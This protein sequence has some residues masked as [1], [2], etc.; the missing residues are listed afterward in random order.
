MQSTD[1]QDRV[2]QEL[3]RRD[4][5]SLSQTV[6]RKATLIV[7]GRLSTG[8][9]SRTESRQLLFPDHSSARTRWVDYGCGRLLLLDFSPFSSKIP[10]PHVSGAFRRLLSH[11]AALNGSMG[12]RPSFRIPYTFMC[13]S[14]HEA[15]P[16]P[17][18]V[19]EASTPPTTPVDVA[20][21]ERSHAPI[22]RTGPV[23]LSFSGCGFLGTYH[24]GV[25]ICFQKHAKGLLSRCNKI[26]GASAGSL[27]SSL[28]LLAPDRMEEGLNNLYKLAD[29]LNALRFGALTPRF[30]LNERLTSIV[31]E[32][33]PVNISK[34]QKILHISLTNQSTRENVLMSSFESRECLLNCLMASCFIPMYSSGIR[35]N[36]PEIHG[37]AYID[38]GFS[39][40][41]HVFSDTPTITVSPFSGNARIAPN[42]RS[43]LGKKI[44][45][46][47]KMRLGGQYLN[48]NMQNIVRGAQALFPPTREVLTS[49]YDM[50][51][52]DAMKFLLD[53]G[54]LERGEGT[55]V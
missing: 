43:P 16:P 22:P 32:Y 47:W 54:L 49:Y 12:K 41:L 23:A 55:A 37:V 40:N 27:V 13:P 48:V 28:F 21:G 34:A 8:D 19:V 11:A 39:E 33:I 9:G 24:F 25:V 44:F 51:Y 18:P 7:R 20:S 5:D 36:A 4:I 17:S 52:R 38:G 31:H 35:E 15:S 45:G 29:E 53:E 26:A 6:Y 3:C 50:G 2:L 14:P 42:D 1:P 10:S 30:H 46:E